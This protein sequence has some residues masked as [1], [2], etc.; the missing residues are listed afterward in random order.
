[1]DWKQEV[2]KL[3]KKGKKQ[4]VRLDLDEGIIKY[5]GSK[6][7][8]WRELETITGDEELVRAFLINH[9]VNDLEYSAESIEIEHP[10]EAERPKA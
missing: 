6:M 3:V 8:L 5:D 7:K 2:A 10:Y 9:L 4:T 1:M